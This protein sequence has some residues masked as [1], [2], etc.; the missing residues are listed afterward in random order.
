MA[1]IGL[2]AFSSYEVFSTKYERVASSK[3]GI[4]LG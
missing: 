2:K 4:L 1:L 3:N